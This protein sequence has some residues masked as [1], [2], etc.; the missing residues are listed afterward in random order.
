MSPLLDIASWILIV[1]G[2]AFV[3]TRTLGPLAGGIAPLEVAFLVA[4]AGLLLLVTRFQNRSPVRAVG[5]PEEEWYRAALSRAILVW[6]LLE[7]VAL[8]G[9]VSLFLTRGLA[10]FL[11][12]FAAALTGFVLLRPGRLAGE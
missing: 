10:A 2:G 7:L 8:F 12:L 4:G 6:S 1:A 3:V 11:V 5:E 9:A